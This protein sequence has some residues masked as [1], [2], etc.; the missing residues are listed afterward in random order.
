MIYIE[1]LTDELEKRAIDYIERIEKTLA[2]LPQAAV[3]PV[4]GVG[5]NV[6]LEAPDAVCA[7]LAAPPPPAPA[8]LPPRFTGPAQDS[9]DSQE[10]TRIR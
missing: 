2:L 3:L 9:Y 10:P 6:L 1:S 4:P 7:L 5:H 8:A